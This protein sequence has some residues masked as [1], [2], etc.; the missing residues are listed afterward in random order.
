MRGGLGGFV[1]AQAAAHFGELPIG[2][3]AKKNVIEKHKS[4]TEA[5]GY[6]KDLGH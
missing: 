1:D 6:Q 4:K 2:L 5:T 3:N